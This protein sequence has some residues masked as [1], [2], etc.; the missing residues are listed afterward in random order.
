MPRVGYGLLLAA[1]GAVRATRSKAEVCDEDYERSNRVLD[2]IHVSSDHPIDEPRILCFVNTISTNHATKARAIKDTWGQRCTRLVFLS[3]A[4]DYDLDAVALDVPADHDHLWQKHKASMQYIWETYRHDFDWFYKADDDA[5][6]IMENLRAFLRSPEIVMQQDIVPL[7]M[8]HRFRLTNETIHYYVG[9]KSLLKE[10]TNRWPNW[11]VFNSGGPGVVMNSLYMRLAVESF[12]K[13]T[14]LSDKYS[15]TLPDDASIAF[16]M[17]WNG[18]FPP[19]TRDLQGRERWHAN[20]PH[21]VYYTNPAN[22]PR[23]VWFNQYHR[24]IGGIQWKEDCC[25]PD[26]IAFHYISPEYMR[27]MERQLYFCRH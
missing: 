21:G 5:Y 25:A 15:V 19:N 24:G 4:T 27:H 11:W 10:Y 26:S 6:V 12:P 18:V 7:Q 3:N 14:C 13:R 22:F 23:D 1:C 8:G 9:D 16:C 20:H 17:A 2:L